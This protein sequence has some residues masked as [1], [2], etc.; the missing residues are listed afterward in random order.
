VQ[1]VNRPDANFRGFCGHVVSGSI[2][3]GDEVTILPSRKQSQVRE[4]CTM[5]GTLSEAG[6]SQAVTVTLE[7]E[8]DV[9]RGDMIVR[10][11]NLPH[12]GR[13]L[14]AMLVWMSEQPLSPGKQYWLKHTTRRNSAEVSEVRYRVDVD[15]LHRTPAA[16][17]SLNE[18]GRCHVALHDPV[19]FDSY[20]R[21]RQT[22][23]FVLVDR[24][25]HETVAAGMII[26]PVVDEASRE[27]W[28]DRPAAER[29]VP[30]VSHV[31][32]E[33]RR[34]QY[35]QAP[36]TILLTGLSGSGKTTIALEL[37]ERLFERGNATVVLDGQSMRLGICRDL[38][39]TA[40]ERSENLR[41]A[42]E[43]AKLVNESGL[44]CIAAFVAPHEAIRSKVRQ[45]IGP[46]RLV[47]VHLSTPVGVCRARDATGRY[48]AADR[49]DIDD[50]PGVTSDYEE[51]TA[52]D[53]IV[54]TEHTSSEAI[55]E[56]IF[57]LL[58]KQG[59]L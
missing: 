57:V 1:W 24:I 50:F 33:R 39:F 20:R 35:R 5:D 22:G 44:I 2:R 48:L 52:A 6:V 47:H 56:S 41:R 46:E 9:S 18:I 53:L 13:E 36:V 32:E 30:A 17:L 45:L 34:E 15:T 12:V 58:K 28:D 27:H 37:E 49:G 54:S 59:L 25:T 10:S 3:A 31:S 14:E 26:D 7:D 16:T 19:M 55:V 21:N 29:L 43:V 8:V 4:I 51:P 40:E 42:A 11:G 38:G 23:A